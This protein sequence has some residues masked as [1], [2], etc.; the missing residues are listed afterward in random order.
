M[1]VARPKS[2]VVLVGPLRFGFS[3]VRLLLGGEE[4][5]PRIGEKA[6]AS[7]AVTRPVVGLALSG[8]PGAVQN[9]F[10]RILSRRRRGD[11]SEAAQARRVGR[12][13]EVRSR[14]CSDL[15]RDFI[16]RKRTPV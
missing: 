11:A 2:L 4:G 14:G 15:G 1:G 7:F 16:R 5:T 10:P 12:G 13:D 3:V 6:D 9:S 8:P